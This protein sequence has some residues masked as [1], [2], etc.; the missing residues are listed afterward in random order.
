VGLASALMGMGAVTSGRAQDT[1]PVAATD[2][3]LSAQRQLALTQ[4]VLSALAAT[5]TPGALTGVW[6]PG[7]GSW[8]LAAGIG[9]LTTAAPLRI[10]DHVRI[11]SI[12]KTF[13]ATVALQLVAEGRLSLDDRLGHFITGIPNG[14]AITLCQLLNMTAGIYNY[15]EA[16]VIAVDYDRDPLLPFTPQQA[17]AIVRAHGRADFPPGARS[18]YSDSN[19]I[20]LGLIL[21]Q[22]TGHAIATEITQRI[23]DPLGLT[24]TSFPTSPAMP[25]PYAHGYAAER[26]GAPVRDVT[27]SNPAVAWAVGA[28]LST[29]DDLCRWVE[30]LVAGS[31]LTPALQAERLTIEPWSTEPISMGYGLGIQ[32]IGGL[33]GH[34]GGILGYGSVVMHDPPSGTT[35]AVVATL[36]DTQGSPAGGRIFAQI[37][38]LLFPHRGFAALAPAPATPAP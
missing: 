12:T 13:V 20:L 27:R 2:A 7:Q 17:V 28:M 6:I 3:P 10:D 36:G 30:I 11:A 23:L 29:L 9:D 34:T 21:E 26:P 32:E 15:I 8:T 24:Q 22:V 1:T 35:L 16:P 33:L 18:V 14:D 5:S 38:D 31:L 25:E 4:I 37:A 19:Y